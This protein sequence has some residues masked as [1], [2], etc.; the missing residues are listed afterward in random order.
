MR[1]GVIATMKRGLE[2]FVF[3]EMVLLQ[4]RGYSIKLLPTKCGP[5]LYMPRSEWE[6]VAWSPLQV[7][8]SQP[9]LF[10]TAP[11]L[12]L[13]LLFEALRYGALTDFAL[14]FYFSKH[15]EDVDVIYSEFG[16]HKLFVGYFCKR[17]LGKPLAVI[18]HAYE[19]YQN[20]NP[21]MFARALAACD[22][23]I[24]VTNF[25]RDYL[26][27]H[28]G[29]PPERV[30]I[31]RSSLDMREY[32]PQEK[33]AVLIVG[34]FVE[35]KGHDILFKAVKQLRNPNI[36]IWVVGGDGAEQEGVDVKQMAKSLEVES[37]VAFFGK[38]SGNALN[39][40]YR[41]CDVFCLPCRTQR[42]GVA[43]GF[44][45]VLIEA[46]AFG[47]PVIT[48]RHVGIP[49][50][51]RE[52]IVEENDVDGLAA[53]IQA[54]Y[55]KREL[56]ERLGRQN[57]K[58]AEEVFSQDNVATTGALLHRIAFPHHDNTS[59]DDSIPSEVAI[60]RGA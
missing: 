43:E 31:V 7:C 20:P 1:I 3:R 53:A 8:L 42:N 38:L 55:E 22:Q 24:T 57:R 41:T 40:V 17:I 52:M 5:G 48:T 10:L 6:T 34:F 45:L 49:E 9:Y 26:R 50:V 23:I 58:I 56:R 37:Q 32:K 29:I 47:K 51:I 33:F 27:D 60:S 2:Q 16:D 15:M 4:E 14:A 18:I 54:T 39:S 13:R 12:Y 35:R 28:F 11:A 21:R 44:P 25:N 46:M 19:L 36:E 59:D 30:A